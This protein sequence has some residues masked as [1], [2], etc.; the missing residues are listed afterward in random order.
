[1]YARRLFDER[2]VGHALLNLERDLETSPEEILAGSPLLAEGLA[3]AESREEDSAE[4]R[5]ATYELLWELTGFEWD[6]D[7]G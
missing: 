3:E 2:D 5:L 6:A 7:A 4:W 1:M